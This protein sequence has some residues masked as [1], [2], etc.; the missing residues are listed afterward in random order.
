[1]GEMPPSEQQDKSRKIETLLKVI[2]LLDQYNKQ[3]GLGSGIANMLKAMV[4]ITVEDPSEQEKISQQ[5]RDE[6]AK[7]QQLFQQI[8]TVNTQ[9]PQEI[10]LGFDFDKNRNVTIFAGGEQIQ[11][12][13]S[14]LVLKD[15]QIF[16]KFLESV[17]HDDLEKNDAGL[18]KLLDQTLS[19]LIQQMLRSYDPRRED[20]RW[21]ELMK[22]AT[23]I[24]PVLMQ[25]GFTNQANLL[26][27]CSTYHASG[28][29]S[30]YL[31]MNQ[32]QCFETPG[33]KTFGPSRWH[34]DC[35]INEYARRWSRALKSV[36][37]GVGNHA[38]I[39]VIQKAITNLIAC[40]D[41]A[42]ADMDVIMSDSSKSDDYYKNVIP[43]HREV[44][45]QNKTK[46]ETMQNGLSRKMN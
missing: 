45:L 6:Q 25:L 10:G 18:K 14:R 3:E 27:M 23:T 32:A 17:T 26:D 34:G 33:A 13:E 38:A 29:L 9:A 40:I 12:N 28:T 37:V 20:N 16:V 11:S 31:T 22:I 1:M 2:S 39:P 5:E 41:Y 44:A 8:Q 30:N 35:S 36:E 4:H 46:L 21:S 42:I 7:Q 24:S 19:I 15:G 43:K